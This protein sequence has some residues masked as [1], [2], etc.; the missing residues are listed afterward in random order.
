MTKVKSNKNWALMISFLLISV[1]FLFISFKLFSIQYSDTTITITHDPSVRIIE[2]P[3]GNII[4]ED[5]RILSVTMPIYDV[6]MDLF[7]INKF[8]FD[9]EVS[10]LSQ[11]LSNLFNDKDPLL[12]EELLR[13][14]QNKRYFL[15]KR[16]VSYLQ[17]QKMKKFPILKMGKY[18]GGFMPEMK[19]TRDYPFGSLGKVTVGNVEIVRTK[20]GKDSIVPK[21]G[22]ELAFNNYLQGISGKEMTQEISGRI[23]IPKQ[24]DL[25]ILPQEGKDVITTIN[26][27]F[28][29]AAESSFREKLLQT[30]ALWGTVVLM[31]VETG[32]IKAIANLHRSKD[33]TNYYDSRN[34]AIVSEIAP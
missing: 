8:L 27:E 34:H 28:Q 9:K 4:S 32:N 13:E 10:N 16:N 2:A 25:N 19:S 30:K 1:F 7:T 18:G 5:G 14:N 23:L 12:Y 15:L 24:S 33:S 22:I 6:R 17:L 11:E 3:R 26:I 20:N 31:E 29:D 21:N